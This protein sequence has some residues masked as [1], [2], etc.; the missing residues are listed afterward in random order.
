MS[1]WTR[2]L[3]IATNF[4][5]LALCCLLGFLVIQNR[6]QKGPVPK[7]VGSVMNGPQINSRLNISGINWSK[8]PKTIVMAISTECHFCSASAPFYKTL[9]IA[10]RQ[11]HERVIAFF[12]QNKDVSQAYLQNKQIDVDDVLQG[13]LESIQVHGT[14]TLLLVD[15]NGTITRSWVGQ[16]SHEVETQVLSEL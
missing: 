3:E 1:R 16:L 14:P 10:A 5:V 7:A 6:F 15:A 4:A 13:A 9:T 2:G 11:K 8:S 12:P